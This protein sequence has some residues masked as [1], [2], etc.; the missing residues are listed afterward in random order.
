MTSSPERT[1]KKT[2]TVALAIVARVSVAIATVVNTCHISYSMH[3]TVLISVTCLFWFC[4]F[5][6]PWTWHCG[7]HPGHLTK[8]TWTLAIIS[9]CGL[10]NTSFN[11]KTIKQHDIVYNGG[12]KYNQSLISFIPEDISEVMEE[13]FLPSLQSVNS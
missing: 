4:D 12:I 8:K 3:V 2:P 10:F 7:R 1:P 11:S 5:L 6:S 9:F 13:K